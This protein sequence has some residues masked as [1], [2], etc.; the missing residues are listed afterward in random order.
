MTSGRPWEAGDVAAIIGDPFYAIEFHPSFAQA[1]PHSLTEA[2]WITSNEVA[3]EELGHE[4][5]LWKL[6]TAL[7]LDHKDPAV[8]SA[9]LLVA[10]PYP[11]ITIDRNLCLPHPPLIKEEEWVRANLRGLEEGVEVWLRNLLTVLKGAFA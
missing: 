10:D 4:E 2:V 3:L 9:R 1:H 7:K 5:W 6:L 11:A 8:R